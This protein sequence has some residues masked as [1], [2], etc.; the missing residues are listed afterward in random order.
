MKTLAQ[1]ARSF[2]EAEGFGADF[3]EFLDPKPLQAIQ[4]EREESK[5]LLP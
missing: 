2:G 5:L 1:E 4:A 3:A